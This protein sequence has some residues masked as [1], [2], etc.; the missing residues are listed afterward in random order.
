MLTMFLSV[1]GVQGGEQHRQSTTSG[2][3]MDDEILSYQSRG[4][5]RTLSPSTSNIHLAKGHKT[6]SAF[7]QHPAVGLL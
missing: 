4:P 6:L 3:L 5:S 2:P 7:H 1:V